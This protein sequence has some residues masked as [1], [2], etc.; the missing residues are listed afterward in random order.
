MPNAL[1]RYVAVRY[2]KYYVLL[3]AV[4]ALPMFPLL[5]DFALSYGYVLLVLSL[6]GAAAACATLLEFGF[7]RELATLQRYGV[8]Y[9][10]V[11]RPLLLSTVA[12]MIAA[13]ATAVVLAVDRDAAAYWSAL[14]LCSSALCVT[15]A[16]KRSWGGRRGR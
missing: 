8:E 15:L 14:G 9:A 16:C 12:P 3:I 1:D 7:R 6:A 11:F 5:R 4:L 10:Q 13:S 2:F